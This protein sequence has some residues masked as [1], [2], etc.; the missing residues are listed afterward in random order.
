[1]TSALGVLPQVDLFFRAKDVEYAKEV[2]A[3]D[4]LGQH[5][6]RLGYRDATTPGWSRDEVG[7]DWDGGGNAAS[8]ASHGIGKQTVNTREHRG[9]QV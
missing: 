5:R 9:R 2:G 1:M 8:P 4:R 6:D 7:T 3:R